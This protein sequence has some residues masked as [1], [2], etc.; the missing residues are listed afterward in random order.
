MGIINNHKIHIAISVLGLLL[1]Y[2]LP[3]SV[4]FTR[5]N[6]IAIDPGFK[7]VQ[8]DVSEKVRVKR[9]VDGD[10][11]ELENG[12]KVRYIG[13]D[14]QELDSS[15]ESVQCYGEEAQ[16]AN[17]DLV[18]GKIIR[19]EKDVTDKDRFDRLLR[20]V[21]VLDNKDGENYELF[22]NDTLV[23][24]GYAKVAT[25][26]PDIKYSE[27]FL[28]GERYAKEKSLGLWSECVNGIDGKVEDLPKLIFEFLNLGY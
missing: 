19:M 25:Y 10:T 21:W 18:L 5:S 15:N 14:T 22:V 9:V 7:D 11:I 20:Y 26:P 13:I 3:N 6:S 8:G 27:L 24:K 4:S 16:K 12:N 23:R 2:L 17:I 28:Q 1:L